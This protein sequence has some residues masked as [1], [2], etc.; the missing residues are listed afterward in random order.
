[1]ERYGLSTQPAAA[2]QQISLLA[3]EDD[4]VAAEAV[5]RGLRMHE[6]DCPIVLAKDGASPSCLS[7]CSTRTCLALQASMPTMSVCS[8]RWVP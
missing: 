4:D 5:V 3:V 6:M 1:M 7:S 8:D 2:V